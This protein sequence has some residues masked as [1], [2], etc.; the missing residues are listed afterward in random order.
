MEALFDVLEVL[1][2]IGWILFSIF[3]TKIFKRKN[4]QK[5]QHEYPE[6][7]QQEEKVPQTAEEISA[8]ER[9]LKEWLE[10]V[11]GG[12]QKQQEPVQVEYDDYEDE[13]EEVVLP[14]KPASAYYSSTGQN[15]PQVD[16]SLPQPKM[17]VEQPKQNKN[18]NVWQG[19]IGRSQMAYGL[20]MSEIFQKPR[21]LRPFSITQVNRKKSM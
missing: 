15:L 5:Q 11:F 20:V 17:R 14:Q 3:G 18:I 19:R 7:P 9:R 2:I 12:E 21:A 16:L 1:I 6:F 13:E 8:E 10:G 4:K